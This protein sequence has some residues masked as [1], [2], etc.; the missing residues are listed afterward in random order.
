ML[1]YARF[2]PLSLL[3][4]ISYRGDLALEAL[5]D[6]AREHGSLGGEGRLIRLRLASATDCSGRLDTGNHTQSWL[7]RTVDA[8][9]LRF[10]LSRPA[11]QDFGSPTQHDPAETHPILIISID[12]DRNRRILDDIA[13][14]LERSPGLA[15]RLLVDRDREHVI[16]D[17]EADRDDVGSRAIIGRCQIADLSRGQERPLE[18]W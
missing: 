5:R 3:R 6:L 13:H 10:V 4:V 8:H 1:R 14:P 15:L 16:D 9:C 18:R 17:R 2:S 7:S 12:D 11:A